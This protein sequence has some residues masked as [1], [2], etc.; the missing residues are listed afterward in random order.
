MAEEFDQKNTDD[1]YE[2]ICFICRRPE[3]KAGKMFKMPGNMTICMDCM[4]K[5]METVSQFDYQSMMNNPAFMNGF[6]PFANPY[7]QTKEDKKSDTEAKD[8]VQETADMEDV[9]KYKML[10][11]PSFPQHYY[12]QSVGNTYYVNTRKVDE[13]EGKVTVCKSAE[14]EKENAAPLTKKQMKK[15]EKQAKKAKKLAKKNKRK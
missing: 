5:T 8:T 12:N 13:P 6:G 2:D 3:S 4:Q 10:T 15:A 9:E 14:V 7:S 1:G 11:D